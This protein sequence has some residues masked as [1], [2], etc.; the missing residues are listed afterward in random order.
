MSNRVSVHLSWGVTIADWPPGKALLGF[1]SETG[2][3]KVGERVP[4]GSWPSGAIWGIV[5]HWLARRTRP[6]GA[7]TEKETSVARRAKDFIL[8]TM[9]LLLWELKEAVRRSRKRARC[10]VKTRIG[11]D[12]GTTL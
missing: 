8:K 9:V 2:N 4:G 3:R 10:Q 12:P 7:A 11:N 1:F 5:G 6:A